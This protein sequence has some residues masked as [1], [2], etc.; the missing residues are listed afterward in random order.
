M[1]AM[2]LP[3][4]DGLNCTTGRWPEKYNRRSFDF[5]PA[6]RDSAQD[7][8]AFFEAQLGLAALAEAV[9]F[10]EAVAGSER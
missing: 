9:G 7:D 1:G 4:D 5:V 10:P 6:G 2:F 3:G 8:S